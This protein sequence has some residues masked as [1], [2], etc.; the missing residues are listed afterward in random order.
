VDEDLG[1]MLERG[2]GGSDL[3]KTKIMKGYLGVQKILE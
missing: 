1:S 2:F 3:V